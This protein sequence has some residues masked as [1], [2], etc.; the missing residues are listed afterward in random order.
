MTVNFYHVAEGNLVS[1]IIRLLEKVYFSGQRCIFFSPLDDR[2][3]TVDK[4]LWT[5][6]TNAFV[7]HGDKN[8]GFSSK[9]PIYFTSGMENPNGATTLML[10]DAFEHENFC[11]FDKVISVFEEQQQAEQAL[12]IW[13][14]FEKKGANANYWLQTSKGWE[15]MTS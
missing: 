2:V 1:A 9:Q 15:Q 14:D 6:S 13:K 5:Y 8:L 7:P 10:V 12:L 4:T 11:L 3:K